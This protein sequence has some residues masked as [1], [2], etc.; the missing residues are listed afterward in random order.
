MEGRT[1]LLL[2]VMSSLM[3]LAAAIDAAPTSNS[4]EGRL[5]VSPQSAMESD[6]LPP[7]DDE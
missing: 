5:E 3:M 1:K 4:E 2:L 7:T 6:D